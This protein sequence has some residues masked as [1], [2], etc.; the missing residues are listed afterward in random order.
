M[1]RLDYKTCKGCGK[2]EQEVGLL[3][4]TRFCATCGTMR[5]REHNLSLHHKSGADFARWRRQMAA[6]VGAVILD[7]YRD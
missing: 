5:E 7:D 1:P 4:H 3:S 6:C 2:H